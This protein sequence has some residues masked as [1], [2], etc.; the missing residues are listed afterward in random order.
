MLSFTM[1]AKMPCYYHFPQLVI[2]LHI[3][4][5]ISQTFQESL[6]SETSMH[7]PKCFSIAT[8]IIQG[9]MPTTVADFL[10]DDIN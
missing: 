6:V 8:C 4:S 10:E 7:H 5:F 9:P 3:Y 2:P 1:T